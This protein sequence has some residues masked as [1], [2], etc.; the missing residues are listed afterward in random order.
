MLSKLWRLPA[1]LMSMINRHLVAFYPTIS[2]P[3]VVVKT[4]LVCV[5]QSPH[6]S[7]KQFTLDR[8]V[9]ATVSY[10]VYIKTYMLYYR[11]GT[12]SMNIPA[13]KARNKKPK[14][15]IFRAHILS[16]WPMSLTYFS[17][18]VINSINTWMLRIVFP[19]LVALRLKRCFQFWMLF[20]AIVLQTVILAF[21][22]P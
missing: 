16:L 19:P 2:S 17:T 9:H 12:G 21:Q 11:W 7:M 22:V 6:S 8:L 1:S 14:T 13:K 18:W 5:P 3:T 15:D 20:I 10:I 4:Q